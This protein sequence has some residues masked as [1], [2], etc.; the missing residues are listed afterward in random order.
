MRKISTPKDDRKKQQKV[1][2]PSEKTLGF[3]KQ[4]ARTYYVETSLPRQV[5][6]ICVN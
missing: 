3:L 4:F 5:N 2:A 1:V 6:E